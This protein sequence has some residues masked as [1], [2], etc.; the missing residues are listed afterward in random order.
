VRAP[1]SMQ[2]I[3][4]IATFIF[5]VQRIANVALALATAE[6]ARRTVD[7]VG[8]SDASDSSP[9]TSHAVLESFTGVLEPTASA[10]ATPM[11]ALS[12]TPS[13]RDD[14]IGLDGPE[15]LGRDDGDSMASA[16]V[17]QWKQKDSDAN[18][19]EAKDSKDSKHSTPTLSTHGWWEW[20]WWN[21]TNAKRGLRMAVAVTIA[22]SLGMLP[23]NRQRMDV[24]VWAAMTTAFV[25]G[26]HVGGSFHQ[27]MLR[28]QG[29]LAG[30]V[31]GYLLLLFAVPLEDSNEEL[32]ATPVGTRAAVGTGMALW[33]MA[34]LSLRP[35]PWAGY[36]GL[37]AGIGAAL[38]VGAQR[39]AGTSVEEFA[40]SR[41]TQTILGIIA[42]V[43]TMQVLWPH[44]ATHIVREKLTHCLSSVSA[45]AST[46]LGDLATWL[47]HDPTSS[48]PSTSPPSTIPLSTHHPEE[49]LDKLSLEM[50]AMPHLVG[51][52]SEEPALWRPAFP[53]AHALAISDEIQRINRA[54]RIALLARA[55][56]EKA[57]AARRADPASLAVTRS[58]RDTFHELA[59]PIHFLALAVQA[60]ARQ[61]ATCLANPS[62]GPN[63]LA[64]IE[65]LSLKVDALTNTAQALSVDYE[66]VAQARVMPSIRSDSSPMPLSSTAAPPPPPL[67]PTNQVISFNAAFFAA[68][69]IALALAN[70]AAAAQKLVQRM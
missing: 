22:G 67:L 66:H 18:S 46:S 51:I 52:A 68:R 59:A 43:L 6:L 28:L 29:T 56:L 69:E 32:S 20:T 34:A 57:D 50:D 55:A 47:A 36:R 35:D 64:D 38:V 58:V 15:G 10:A 61:T 53:T 4:P 48:T 44:K 62:L 49:T 27:S 9:A 16:G 8:G 17:L 42:S 63:A 70:A 11:T 65:L 60:V 37:V 12:A 7:G 13:S 1:W 39:P 23:G 21:W 14:E 3:V 26:D 41:I 2:E 19:K 33:A 24:T 40:V 25:S 30:A 45:V 5:S 54:S 31:F